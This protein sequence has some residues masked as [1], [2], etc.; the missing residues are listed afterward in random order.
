MEVEL[1][2]VLEILEEFGSVVHAVA[3]VHHNFVDLDKLGGRYTLV[4]P[5]GVNK[6]KYFVDVLLLD[7]LLSFF[8]AHLTTILGCLFDD[9]FRGFHRLLVYRKFVHHSQIYFLN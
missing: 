4:F 2:D 3:L 1:D 9:W 5:I 8:V 6:S 7:H